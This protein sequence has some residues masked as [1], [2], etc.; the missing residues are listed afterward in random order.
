MTTPGPNY[1]SIALSVGTAV[2]VDA[3]HGDDL[4]AL[5]KKIDRGDNKPSR[6]LPEAWEDERESYLQ[7]HKAGLVFGPS[8]ERLLFAYS[9]HMPQVALESLPNLRLTPLGE[10][11]LKLFED[12]QTL[13]SVGDDW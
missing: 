10:R 2:L 6:L 8:E 13:T 9:S 12:Y 4:Q 1:L 7:L 5:A 11:F 3:S